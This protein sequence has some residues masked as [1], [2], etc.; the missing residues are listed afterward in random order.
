ML[1]PVGRHEPNVADVR[2]EVPR[3]EVDGHDGVAPER[4]VHVEAAVHP[5]ARRFAAELLLVHLPHRNE[6][7]TIQSS[8]LVCQQRTKNADADA[9]QSCPMSPGCVIRPRQGNQKK[10]RSSSVRPE[11]LSLAASPPLRVVCKQTSEKGR[12]SC[13]PRRF[14]FKRSPA[15]SGTTRRS[16]NAK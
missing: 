3:I 13:R 1:D 14:L 11:G 15:S 7:K 16:A 5:S 9:R 6:N 2:V 8:L 12:R 4:R 10:P